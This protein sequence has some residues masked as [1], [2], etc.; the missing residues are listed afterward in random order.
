MNFTYKI[1]LHNFF[2][3]IWHVRMRTFAKDSIRR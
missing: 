2:F 1:E 3:D